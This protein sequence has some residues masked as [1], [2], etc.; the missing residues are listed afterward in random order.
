M[1]ILYAIQRHMRYQRYDSSEAIETLMDHWVILRRVSLSPLSSTNA[2]SLPPLVSRSSLG[3]PN[4]T[5]FPASRTIY[6]NRSD[7]TGQ[8][9]SPILLTILSASMMVCNLWAIVNNVTSDPRLVRSEFWIT[10]SV[11]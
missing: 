11:S 5:T 10:V 7:E 4:S 2:L 8:R 6:I 1:S 9:M 3:L